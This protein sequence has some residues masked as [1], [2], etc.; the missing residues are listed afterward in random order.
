MAAYLVDDYQYYLQHP[1]FSAPFSVYLIIRGSTYGIA[2]IFGFM[3]SIIF[4]N[5]SDK[6]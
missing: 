2:A 4:K 6:T 5:K 1:E 3:L